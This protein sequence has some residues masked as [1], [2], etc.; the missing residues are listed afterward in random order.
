MR[1]GEEPGAEEANKKAR[2]E[3]WDRWQKTLKGSGK[4]IT[5]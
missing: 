4:S 3:A 2:D 5:T 1:S